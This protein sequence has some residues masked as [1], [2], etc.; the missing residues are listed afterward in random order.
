MKINLINRKSIFLYWLLF[1]PFLQS[2]EDFLDKTPSSDLAEEAV[3]S[4]YRLFKEYVD[5]LYPFLWYTGEDFGF[6]TYAYGGFCRI[7]L[8]CLEDATDLSDGSRSDCGVRTGFN[9]GDWNQSSALRAEIVYPWTGGYSAIRKANRILEYVDVIEGL[10]DDE[11]AHIKG[12]ALFF[13]GFFYHE[14]LKRYGGIPYI[15]RATNVADDMDF[16]RDTY[17]DCV[18]KMCKDFDEAAA[19]LP[20]EFPESELGRPGRGA[21]LGYKARTLLYAASPLNNESNDIDQWRKAA[22]AAYAVIAMNHYTLVPKSDYRR[23]FYGQPTNSEVLFL[24]N[25]GPGGWATGDFS[26]PGWGSFELGVA[27]RPW[28]GEWGSTPCPTQNLLDM[29]EMDNGEKPILGYTGNDGTKPIINTASGYSEEKM[30]E[31]RDPRFYTTFL[32]NGEPWLDATGGIEL[33]FQEDGTPGKHIKDDNAW[34]QTG[35]LEKKFWD[36]VLAGPNSGTTYLNWIFLRYTDILLMY[37]EAMNEAFGPD[38]DGL[39]KGLTARQAVNQVRNRVGMINVKANTKEELRERIQNERAIEFVYEDQRWFDVI[40]WKKGID[41]F[42]Q[43]VYGIRTIKLAD[44]T[45]RLERRKIRDR[46]FKDYMH[47]YPVPRVELNKSYNLV[48]NPGWDA[49]TDEE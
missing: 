26:F 25:G 16:V 20:V 36:P 32:I 1:L 15:D 3:F 40:R 44:G 4:D 12:Q 8:S 27:A 47:R 23:I 28:A 34:T 17:A 21:A 13:R 41:V 19:L 22:E 49:V 33:F 5:G 31:H 45:F 6:T 42:N 7:Q 37:A 11:R 35:Y 48:N 46:V 43:P 39:N 30:Y 24:R 10:T 18:E 14:M 29:Y 38:A 9:M 2:C